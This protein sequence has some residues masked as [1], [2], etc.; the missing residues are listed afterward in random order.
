MTFDPTIQPI[1]LPFSGTA[2]T[3][4]AIL[5]WLRSDLGVTSSSGLVSTWL[6]SLGVFGYNAIQSTSSNQPSLVLN[7]LN[8]YP[9][10]KTGT[11]K[12]F[13]LD[14]G[15]AHVN[16]NI[17]GFFIV[18]K[19]NSTSNGALID[20]S[21][22]AGNNDLQCS[23]ASPSATFTINQG[24][25][26]AS[27][28]ASSATSVGQYA[29]LGMQSDYSTDPVTQAEIYTNGVLDTTGAL[30]TPPYSNVRTL[31]HVG[32]DY[33]TSSNF[34]DGELLEIIAIPFVL[35]GNDYI[36][37]QVDPYFLSRYQILTQNPDT[38]IISMP[39]GSLSGPTQVGIS[40]PANCV[41]KYTLDG[42][43]PTSASPTYTE[44][45]DVFYSQTLNAIAIKN[46][47]SSSVASSTY[48]LDSTQWPA[49]DP[50][51]TTPLQG[52][53]C[54]KYILVSEKLLVFDK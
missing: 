3:S 44:P 46:G 1:L 27:L 37:P 43:T 40:V 20:F 52:E 14:S 13:T 2:Y 48:T 7:A 39:S 11:N 32:T 5:Q 35:P 10:I 8:G 38:P 23:V 18:M 47:F 19:P 15:G 50:S 25:T 53:R 4:Q 6:S 42:T 51:D 30:G 31:M 45:I 41:C 33:S 21:G 54:S 16:I 49:P 36:P 29:A 12:Y 28:T 24:S 34:F 9:S 17:P 22:T 26:P